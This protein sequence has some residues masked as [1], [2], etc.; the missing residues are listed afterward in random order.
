MFT[1]VLSEDLTGLVQVQM[2]GANIPFLLQSPREYEL[3]QHMQPPKEVDTS[4]VIMSPMPGTLISYAVQEGDKVVNG[5]ELCI[6]EAMKM[7]NIIRSPCAGTIGNCRVKVGSSL[8]ADE[9]IL[10]FAKQDEEEAA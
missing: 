3:S 8:K 2:Y 7:Q 5:Q 10:E 1:Q 6:V 4:D 9:I